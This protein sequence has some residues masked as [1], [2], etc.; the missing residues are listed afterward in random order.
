MRGVVGWDSFC[1]CALGTIGFINHNQT[2]DCTNISSSAYFKN[3]FSNC[4]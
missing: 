2:S 3:P 4:L 1:L